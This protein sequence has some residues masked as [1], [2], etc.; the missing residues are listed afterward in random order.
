MK[1]VLIVIDSKDMNSSS[2]S[3]SNFTISYQNN[4]ILNRI[5]SYFIKSVSVPNV[6]YNIHGNYVT[7][8]ANN[9]LYIESSGGGLQSVI[10]I[11]IGQYTL[12]QLITAITGSATGVSLGLAIT[13]DPNTGLLTITST[14]VGGIKIYSR[15]S[16][17]S[18][19]LSPNIGI[20][21]QTAAFSASIVSNGMPA[22]SGN[23]NIYIGSVKMASGTTLIDSRFNNLTVISTIPVNVPFGEVIH[24]ETFDYVKDTI[25]S[26]QYLNL[27]EIDIRLYNDYGAI[28]DLHGEPFTMIIKAFY[29]P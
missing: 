14:A 1:G 17:P 26:D 13:Q 16:T 12:A 23:Q 21:T 4:P 22:L 9:L 11:P 25:E 19:T 28:L 7:E 27:R 2:V 24:Y 8:P 29:E 20:T 18:S 6:E 5:K 15:S 10:T 3:T